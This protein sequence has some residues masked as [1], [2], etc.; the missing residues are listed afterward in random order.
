[1]TTWNQLV[2]DAKASGN[3]VV[4]SLL[5]PYFCPDTGGKFKRGQRFNVDPNG[6]LWLKNSQSI[7]W[8]YQAAIVVDGEKTVPTNLFFIEA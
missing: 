6:E 1:M 3:R 8:Q 7:K 4:V 5:G 2:E